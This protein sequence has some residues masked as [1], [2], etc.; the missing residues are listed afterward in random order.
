MKN[1]IVTELSTLQLLP[2]KREDLAIEEAHKAG[3]YQEEILFTPSADAV[4]NNIVP[5]CVMGYLYGALIESFCSEQNSRMMAMEAANKN[6]ADMVHD[7]SIEY[8]RARQAM[9]TQEI[10]EVISGAKAQKKKKAR[11]EGR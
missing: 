7:L 1:S 6:A 2:L 5:D 10:T 11:K 9:I 8:N 4:L 3:I